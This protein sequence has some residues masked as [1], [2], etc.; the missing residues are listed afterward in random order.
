[1]SILIKIEMPRGCYQCLFMTHCEECEGHLNHCI[2]DED[3]HGFG[4]HLFSNLEWK[5][6]IVPMERP[7]WCPL[8]ELPPHGR[9]IDADV[10]YDEFLNLM[11]IQGAI[12]PCQLGR[13]LVCAPTIIESEGEE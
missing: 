8:I 3:E 12:D 2:L 10:A 11:K 9:L 5:Y 1:M 13:I 7:S 6:P 4:N